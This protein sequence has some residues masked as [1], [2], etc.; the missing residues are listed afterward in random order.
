[1]PDELH[2]VSFN[3]GLLRWKVGP[4]K[5]F[6]SPPHVHDRFVHI[7]AAIAQCG[8]D[9]I[10][11]QEIYEQKHVDAVLAAAKPAGYAHHARGDPRTRPWIQFHN[12]LLCLSK[13]PID[14]FE[15]LKHAQCSS[16]EK[17]L[18]CKSA[19]AVRVTTPVGKLCF[20]NLHTTA[21][22]GSD[23]EAGDVDTARQSELDEAAQLCTAAAADGYAGIVCGDL[24]CGPE[25]S[26]GNYE[27]LFASG[28]AD[29]L[30]GFELG[31][32]WDPASPLNNMPV[33]QGC[34]AQRIDHF[35]VHT[36]AK[37]KATTAERCFTEPCVKAKGGKLDVTLS[38][39]YGIRATLRRA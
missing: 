6:E 36:D 8:A 19:L 11:L 33:F 22:G 15:C 35:L 23:P 13:L 3:L 34:P 17:T 16:L 25:A 29:I 39:H 30:A 12:G 24:N 32:T 18:G 7:P 20:V 26:S 21:G 28:Y 2:V 9:I 37:L 38:D 10:L 14:G 5:L 27:H 1:M 31:P 4:L